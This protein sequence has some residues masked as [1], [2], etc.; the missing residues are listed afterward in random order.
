MK[1]LRCT[2]A[3]AIAAILL[4]LSVAGCSGDSSSPSAP[5]PP[6]IPDAVGTYTAGGNFWTLTFTDSSDQTTVP[7]GGRITIAAQNGS[8]ISGTYV[9]A[10][11]NCTNASGDFRGTIQA[12]G[13]VEI[14][15]GVSA[16]H[17]G[18]ADSIGCIV[19]DAADSFSGSLTGNTLS[20]GS[21][22]VMSCPGGQVTFS[23]DARG[24]R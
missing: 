20:I 5:P 17:E 4:A 14:G 6:T 9:I 12:G 21:A 15:E 23:L 24:S 2:S 3:P 8:A 18:I 1:A 11:P 13:A 19:V 22:S 10:P 7:C 16:L